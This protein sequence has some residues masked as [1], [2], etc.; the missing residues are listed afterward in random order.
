MHVGL[1]PGYAGDPEVGTRLGQVTFQGNPSPGDAPA[2]VTFGHGF[3]GFTVEGITPGGRTT[4]TIIFH[5]GDT[6]VSY[7]RYG[8]TPGNTANHWYEFNYNGRTGAQVSRQGDNTHISLTFWDG[9]RGDDDLQADGSIVDQGGPGT[10][11][12]GA[13]EDGG[14][15]ISTLQE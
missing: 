9:E 6:V 14:C 10:L 11:L 3:F 7:W 2:G 8:P 1:C 12:E 4:V 5:G 13:S 15:F